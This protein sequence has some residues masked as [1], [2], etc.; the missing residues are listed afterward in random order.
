[1]R[2]ITAVLVLALLMGGTI[3]AEQSVAF[4]VGMVNNSVNFEGLGTE[5]RYSISNV[6][7]TVDAYNRFE[8]TPVSLIVTIIFSMPESLK[9][10]SVSVNN[11][12][13][14][15]TMDGLFGLGY[16]FNANKPFSL[17]VGGG[18]GI[19]MYSIEKKDI[20]TFS[21][22]AL[23]VGATVKASYMFT[24]NIG[25]AAIFH[26]LYC[27]KTMGA[28]IKIGTDFVTLDKYFTN[29]N[30]LSLS[31]ALQVKM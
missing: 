20:Y 25:V 31:L 13:F 28:T 2:K 12:D 10:D 30:A 19:S 1:M 27:P 16:I 21:V 9:I 22:M 15:T 7:F 18:F 23:G 24:P 17:L 26:D 14:S 3:F 11:L 6:G 4:G 5:S 8:N 29:S